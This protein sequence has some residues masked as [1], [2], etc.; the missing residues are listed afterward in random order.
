MYNEYFQW[1]PENN[2]DSD[3]H[4]CQPG[5]VLHGVVT[6]SPSDN[7]YNMVHTNVN[8]GWSVT[9][10]IPIQTDPSS[11]ALKNYTIVYIVY[12]KDA[13]C[14][15]YP[16][17]G[18]VTFFDVRVEYDNQPIV[19]AWKTGIVDDVC[20]NR[21]HVLNATTIQITWDTQAANPDPFRQRDVKRRLHPM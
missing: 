7:S 8:D 18:Q 11:G 21:A 13:D 16:A 2:V 1:S 4:T 9:T 20:N 19:P 17:D 5:D 3:Q 10:K 6:Y 15:Q 12:E 14:N